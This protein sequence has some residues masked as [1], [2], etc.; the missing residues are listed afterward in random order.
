MEA[1]D[2]PPALRAF[3]AEKLI[4][5]LDV[6]ESSPLSAKWKKEVRRRCVEVD[7]GAVKLRD[8]DAVFTKAYASLA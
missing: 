5:S 7:R 4:E 6:P 3:V 2:L 8:A 1:M